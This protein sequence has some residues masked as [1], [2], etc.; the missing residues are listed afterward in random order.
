MEVISI[1]NVG[2][3]CV[4]FIRGIVFENILALDDSLRENLL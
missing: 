3:V 1:P 2:T 4:V